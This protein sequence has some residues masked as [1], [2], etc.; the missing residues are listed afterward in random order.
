[1][2]V[3]TNELRTF[4]VHAG[5]AVLRASAPRAIDPRFASIVRTLGERKLFAIE[6]A[7]TFLDGW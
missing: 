1:M 5:A 4:D 2:R 3:R 6:R 7:G